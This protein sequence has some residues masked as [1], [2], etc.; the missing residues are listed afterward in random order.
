M[1]LVEKSDEEI[2]EIADPLIDNLVK[3]S[4]NKDYLG[5]IKNFSKS[6]MLAASEVE[7]GK[8]WTSVEMLTSLS[9]EREYLGCLRRNNHVTVLYKQKSFEIPGDFLGRLVIGIE[10]GEVKIFGVTIF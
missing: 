9:N 5:F 8:Q 7:I 6:M 3:S 4:N 2:I 10:D 1:K